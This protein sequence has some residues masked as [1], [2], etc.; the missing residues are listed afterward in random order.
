MLVPCYDRKKKHLGTEKTFHTNAKALFCTLIAPFE[1]YARETWILR[2]EDK[3]RL[4]TFDNNFPRTIAGK[5]IR[6]RRAAIR[7]N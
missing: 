4:S 7:K 3:Q 5:N 6:G 1:Y 2:K